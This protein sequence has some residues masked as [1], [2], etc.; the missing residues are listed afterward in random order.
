MLRVL[1]MHRHNSLSFTSLSLLYRFA[2]V[3]HIWTLFILLNTF[4]LEWSGIVTLC[5][6]LLY[7]TRFD[8]YTI[9][10][11]VYDETE[12]NISVSLFCYTWTLFLLLKTFWHEWSRLVKYCKELLYII[13]F[14][15]YTFSMT[16]F[17][18]T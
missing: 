17:D 10:M 13:N 9:S 2:N 15:V 16:L 6:G 14:D 7:I 3:L 4:W 5:N 8:L 18:A 11:T 1:D 12:H